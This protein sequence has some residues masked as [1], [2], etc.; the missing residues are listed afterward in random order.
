MEI[1]AWHMKIL[2]NHT[3]KNN[4]IDKTIRRLLSENIYCVQET[5]LS[6]VKETWFL[7]LTV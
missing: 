1:S 7:L 2:Q 3:A 6:D 5:H 4:S